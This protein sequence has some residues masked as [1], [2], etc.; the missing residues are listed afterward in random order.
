[1]AQAGAVGG[2]Y[3]FLDAANRQHQ[4]GEGEFAGHGQV[5][6]HALAAVGGVEGGGHGHAGGGA[7]LGD[8]AGRHVD[9]DAAVLDGGALQPQGVG[10]GPDVA[11]GRLGGF[12]HHLAQV[13]GEGHLFVLLG[14]RRLDVEHVAAGLGPSQTG[15]HAGGDLLAA[16][17][18][19]EFF[20]AE[21]FA[22]LLQADLAFGVLGRHHLP[23]PLAGQPADDPLQLPH[24]GLAGVAAG[25]VGERL[26]ADVEL[27]LAQAGVGLLAWN[28]VLAGD[29]P[30]LLV[31]V[32]GQLQNLDAVEQRPRN[33]LQRVGGGQ[34]QH[35]G[36]VVGQVEVVVA[37]LLVLR[38]IENLHQR[39]R[40]VA[41]KVPAEL[42]DFVEHEDRIG[43]PGTAHALQDAARHGADVG[44]AVAAQLGFVVQAA[45]AHA[46]ELAA[47]GPGDGLAERSLADPGRA[48]EAE[49]GGLGVGIELHDGEGLQNPLLDVLQPVVVLVEHLAG[50]V[51]VQLILRA[52]APRQFG[53]QLQVG[54]GDLVIRGVVGHAP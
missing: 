50:V 54:A 27:R 24:P 23:G 36:Q 49:D 40:R 2:Q 48:D 44:A 28:Q 3:L 32:A 21:Q 4:P 7:V 12:L 8:G 34:K 15:S 37:E 16:L 22:Q 31:A 18:G 13:A 39:R 17:V 41:A 19:L 42:V 10:D 46:L 47:H 35:L 53:H 33:A 29:G 38:R 1:M 20:R 43:D 9:V 26:I 25:H 45:E 6:A 11:A 52:F 14:Q 51:E 30:L 5:V